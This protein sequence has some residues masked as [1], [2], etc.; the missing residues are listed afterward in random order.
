M[1][2]LNEITL[3]KIINFGALKYSAL[4]ICKLLAFNREQTQLFLIDFENDASPIR[5]NY[6]QGVAI[7]EYN[8]DAELAKQ[9]EKG[10]IYSIQELDKR[11]YFREL[12]DLTKELFGV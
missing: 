4:K 11:Q 12:D 9:S 6:D 3:K 1:M 7:G 5:I 2:Q 8:V 10:D